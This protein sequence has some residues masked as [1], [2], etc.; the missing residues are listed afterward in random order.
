MAPISSAITKKTEL[1]L[2]ARSSLWSDLILKIC[3]CLKHLRNARG[4][5][6]QYR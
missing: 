6:I 4:N 3:V 5:L 1:E 2:I